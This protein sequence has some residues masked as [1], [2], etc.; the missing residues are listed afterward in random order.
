MNAR[1]TRGNKLCH[2]S[3][4][5]KGDSEAV[6]EIFI[7]IDIDFI[8]R[9]LEVWKEVSMSNDCSV[10]DEAKSREH[11][12]RYCKSL[13]KV[14]AAVYL[15]NKAVLSKSKKG[16]CSLIFDSVVADVECA[17]ALKFLKEDEG[18]S[19]VIA[20]RR[21]FK[22]FSLAYSKIEV[23]DM[24]D[25]VITYKGKYKVNKS[26]LLIFYECLTVLLKVAKRI[27]DRETK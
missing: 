7:E 11:L 17:R 1:L 19:P 8:Y 22:K 18:N 14:V 16:D 20:I 5:K 9:E 13:M 24:L 3:L 4:S 25:A 23:R 2:F 10:Y 6:R 12:F 15:V 27:L 21:H 26:C